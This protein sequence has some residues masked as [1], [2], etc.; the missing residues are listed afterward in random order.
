MHLARVCM[1]PCV[2]RLLDGKGGYDFSGVKRWTRKVDIFAQWL[3]LFPLN[4]GNN[5]WSLA[6]LAGNE[7]DGFTLYHLDSLASGLRCDS[8][9]VRLLRRIRCESTLLNVWCCATLV[10]EQPGREG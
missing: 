2:C 6:A 3:T 4:H 1:C 5:H 9:I 10:P 7:D 8:N